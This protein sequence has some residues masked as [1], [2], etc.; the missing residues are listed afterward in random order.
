MKWSAVDLDAGQITVHDN[1]V[2]VGGKAAGQ[3]G[4][5]D[6]Q[7]G[8]D[9]LDRPRYG[10][11]TAA[12]ARGPNLFSGDC[13]LCG[14]PAGEFSQVSYRLSTVMSNN[15]WLAAITSSLRPHVQ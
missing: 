8:Q 6:T 11:G 14:Q 12:V 4:R 2:V 7:C 15:Q 13:H 10:R 5:Q 9:D 1:R 3:S